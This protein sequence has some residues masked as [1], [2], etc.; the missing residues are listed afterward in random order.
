MK[1]HLLRLGPVT[2][3]LERL[4]VDAGSGSVTLRPKSFDVLRYLME[5]SGRVVAKEE[6]IDAVW[7]GITVSDESLAQCIS[8]VRRVLGGDKRD[9]I[10]T[11]PKRGYMVD[12]PPQGP[13]VDGIATSQAP[14]AGLEVSSA[15]DARPYPSARQSSRSAV[16]EDRI[17]WQQ[18]L[19]AA[20]SHW[21]VVSVL[22]VVGI[23]LTAAIGAKAIL[24]RSATDGV[25]QGAIMCDKLPWASGRMV[26]HITINI[27]DGSASYSRLLFSPE[28]LVSGKEEG[29]GTVDETGAVKLGGGWALDPDIGF[30]SAYSGT[31]NG[32]MGE[33][34]GTQIWKAHEL[35]LTRKCSIKVAR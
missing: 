35:Q 21:R 9:L 22:L 20:K 11:V 19:S 5:H 29:T 16:R 33:L 2:L 10:R 6:L 8:E 7:P 3:D 34:H 18:T 4:C 24:S 25:W 23:A 14:S 27:S 28:G 26:A 17:R 13:S 12:G 15:L 31:L 32:Q 30:T 1:P